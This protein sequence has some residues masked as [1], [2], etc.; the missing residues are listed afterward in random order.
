MNITKHSKTF[1]VLEALRYGRLMAPNLIARKANDWRF[2]TTDEYERV[3]TILRTLSDLDLVERQIAY[4]T[5]RKEI[6]LYIITVE[7]KALFEKAAV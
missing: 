5:E 3:N 1:R 2:I 6:V 7:G 4:I